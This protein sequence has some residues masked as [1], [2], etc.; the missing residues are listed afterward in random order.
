M[1]LVRV[2]RVAFVGCGIMGAPIASRIMDAGFD[3]TVHNRTKEKAE[4]L[5]QKGAHWAES[6][7][8]AARDA[9]V[10]F[11][12]VGYPSDV[13]DVYLGKDG[14]LD[15]A[16]KGSWM[17]DL[18][19]SSPTLARE[20][21]DAAAVMDKHAVD[22][23]VTGGQQ[24]AEDG[25]LTLMMG[26]TEDEAKVLLPVL[27]AFGKSVH[28]LGRAGNGQ[29]C[30]LCNQV[31]LAS[32]MVGYA[33]ALAL[34]QESGLDPDQVIDVLSGGMANSA[35]LERLAPKSV[36]GDFA[37]GFLSEHMRKDIALALRQ[38]EDVD[39]TLPGADTA[40]NLYDVLCQI[41]GSKLGTQAL[42]L[43]YADE[44]TGTAAGLDWSLLDADPYAD[45]SAAASQGA[46]GEKGA[47][48]AADAVTGDAKVRLVSRTR[49]AS[50]NGEA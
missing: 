9:D 39:V 41:G 26:A 14:I 10:T 11:T 1:A 35:A 36:V 38:A 6:P 23:P 20:L 19:T 43:L 8:E 34:A 22:C 21:H 24:G 44:A 50:Q 18:T 13:E 25:T 12:M 37:P 29:A 48:S 47:P 45:A 30:K 16:R 42:T 40:F 32:C 33:D 3:V 28:Y 17:V 46:Q 27:Q 4:G 15:A 7:A 5:L 2:R 49:R 31:A